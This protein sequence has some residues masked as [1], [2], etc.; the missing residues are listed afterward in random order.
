MLRQDLSSP[1]PYG[2]NIANGNNMQLCGLSVSEKQLK[3]VKVSCMCKDW[4]ALIM[5]RLNMGGCHCKAHLSSIKRV[6][7][8]R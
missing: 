6:V 4:V 8:R 3:P 7:G 1:L 5:I 2:T